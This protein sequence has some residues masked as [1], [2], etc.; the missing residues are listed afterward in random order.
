MASRS[1]QGWHC[2]TLLLIQNLLHR[3]AGDF[4]PPSIRHDRPVVGPSLLL[5]AALGVLCLAFP[6]T[7]LAQ[8]VPPALEAPPARPPVT[9]SN[10][11]KLIGMPKFHDPAPYDINE[12]TGYIQIV[13]VKSCDG[14]AAAPTTWRVENGVMG[15]E[16]LEGK[17]KGNNPIVYRGEKP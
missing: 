13:D 15:G 7:M 4:M 12:H 11:E 2:A 16:T 8:S 17:P 1:I 3:K 9:G 6:A 10:G 5:K 14:W